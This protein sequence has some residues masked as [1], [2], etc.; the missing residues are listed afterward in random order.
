MNREEILQYTS[1]NIEKDRGGKPT[2]NTKTLS[3]GSTVLDYVSKEENGASLIGRDIILIEGDEYTKFSTYPTSYEISGNACRLN[4]YRGKVGEEEPSKMDKFIMVSEKVENEVLAM[5][6]ALRTSS[7]ELAAQLMKCAGYGE[8]TNKE[9]EKIIDDIKEKRGGEPIVIEET[10]N[11]GTIILDCNSTEKGKASRIG[12]DIV[13]INGSEYTK[14]STYPTR[15]GEQCW[16]EV[17]KGEVGKEEAITK[18]TQKFVMTKANGDAEIQSMVKCLEERP[19]LVGQLKKVQSNTG[20]M[21][22]NMASKSFQ[23]R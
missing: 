10:L 5:I 17:E 22:L 13:L 21:N 6:N 18:E 16:L 12:R 14:F 20:P 8:I 4:V 23:V 15:E 7:P 9:S 3:D 11:D 1:E 2:V 19:E